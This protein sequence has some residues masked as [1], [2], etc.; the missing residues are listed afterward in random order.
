MKKIASGAVVFLSLLFLA[1]PAPA[2]NGKWSVDKAHSNI[3]FEIRHTYAMVRGQFEKFTGSIDF[4]PENKETGS[5]EFSVDVASINTLI[6]KR[7]KHLRSEDFFHVE[8]YPRMTFK[9]SSVRKIE[10]NSFVIDGTLTIKGVSKQ[11][12][13]PFTYLGMRDNPLEN[14]QKVAGFE[15]EFSINRLEYNVGTGKF[16][17]MGAVGETVD[18][19]ITLEVLKEK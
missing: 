6:P 19:L 16:A 13:V 3:Y 18:V 11:V 15:A 12:A 7:D 17:E 1:G 14:G 4:N 9:S 10:E 8:K 5:A 2:E